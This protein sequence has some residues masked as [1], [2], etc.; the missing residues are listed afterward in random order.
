M[1]NIVPFLKF[2]TNFRLYLNF[3][4]N[5]RLYEPR[6]SQ[7]DRCFR[8]RFWLVGSRIFWDAQN[9]SG[10]GRSSLCNFVNEVRSSRCKLFLCIL[11]MIRLVLI[12]M[13][14][15]FTFSDVTIAVTFVNG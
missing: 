3:R 9:I 15:P 2:R 12:S 14:F 8:H 11:F 10:L 1:Q 7:I 13:Y 6:L 4:A 5:F